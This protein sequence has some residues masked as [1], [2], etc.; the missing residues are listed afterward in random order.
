MRRS[1]TV[2]DCIKSALEEKIERMI[3]F[4][5]TTLSVLAHNSPNIS[6]AADTLRSRATILEAYAKLLRDA[7]DSTGWQGRYLPVDAVLAENLIKC[8]LTCLLTGRTKWIFSSPTT[9]FRLEV[10]TYDGK[11]VYEGEGPDTDILYL[12]AWTII[13]DLGFKMEIKPEDMT[14]RPVVLGVTSKH[15]AVRE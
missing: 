9:T 13:S 5:K 12:E 10:T 15:K 8:G 11:T 3:P 4:V 2:G 14:A 1:G 7:A 6:L